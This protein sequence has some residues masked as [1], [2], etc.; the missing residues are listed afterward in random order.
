[1]KNIHL[2]DLK[3][4]INLLKKGVANLLFGN[5]DFTRSVEIA[6]AIEI[7]GIT[8]ERKAIIEVLDI[9]S[10]QI[11]SC[12]LSTQ[13]RVSIEYAS[14]LES[15]LLQ[16]ESLAM[17]LGKRVKLT[18]GDARY[19]DY[20]KKYDYIFSIS[21]LE[22]IY[23]EDR[24]EVLLTSRISEFLSSGGKFIFSVPFYHK[25]FSEYKKM[26]VYERSSGGEKIF[27]QRFYD[28]DLLYEN[29]IKPSALDVLSKSYIGE[30]FYFN[31]IADR[32][33]HLFASKSLLK[34]LNAW[35]FGIFPK[36]F[37]YKIDNYR[38][39]KKPYLAIYCLGKK[40]ENSNNYHS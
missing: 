40:D 24:G 15:E 37:L 6:E 33:G 16:M 9:S 10:P 30:R 2:L 22:H 20:G 36:I 18:K 8:K 31:N 4:R 27:F 1:V 17:S 26:D 25:R 32:I 28:E 38:G 12:F 7:S 13:D 19:Y 5:I 11:L 21:V 39:I 35:S 34:I 23:P 29:I 3:I 14:I